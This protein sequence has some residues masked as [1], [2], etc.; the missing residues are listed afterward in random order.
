[1]T[2]VKIYTYSHNRPDFIELQY[3]TIKRHVKDDF[4]FIVFNN[5]RDGGD[6]GFDANKITQINQICE[7]LNI[8][9]IRVELDSELQYMNN[10]KMFDGDRYL[11]GN[12]ACA[13]SYTWGW[14]NYISKNDCL[15]VIIDSD[16]FLIKDVSFVEM[17]EGYNFS[18]VPS[19]RLTRN[20]KDENDRGEIA[21]VY[22]WNGIVMAKTSELPNASEMSWGWG[23]VN[24]IAVDVG[25]ELY[26][27]IEKYK[28]QVKTLYIDQWGLL[29]D[30]QSPFEI[31]INGCSQMFADFEKCTVDIKNYQHSNK[32]TFPHQTDRDNYWEY[33][34]ENYMDIIKVMEKYDFPKPTF[35]DFMK[36]EKDNNVL[37]DSFIFHYK[38]ASNTLPWMNENYNE[39]KTEALKRFLESI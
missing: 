24:N 19:Y 37:K 1:M 6:G 18:Y 31:C 36:L 33:V 7:K 21:F 17:M 30:V 2:K 16:M 8:E 26:Y 14:K 35:V 4:E 39:I 22:P 15:S 12:I 9:C 11:N 38:N 23:Y 5:E 27:Y 3:N 28:D 29:V 13:Y 25:G 10:Q 34:Y 32:K 20:Y